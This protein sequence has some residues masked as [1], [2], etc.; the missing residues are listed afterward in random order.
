M[1]T[2]CPYCDGTG[3]FSPKTGM[4]IKTVLQDDHVSHRY[5]TWLDLLAACEG[6]KVLI[7][8]L[9]DDTGRDPYNNDNYCRVV[10]A[11]AKAKKGG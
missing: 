3:R 9:Y 7:E 6:A 11:I 1:R 10:D 5:E 8:V 2:K 4:E